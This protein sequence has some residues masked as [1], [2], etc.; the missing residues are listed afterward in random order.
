VSDAERE[1]EF[2]T[3]ARRTLDDAA[4]ATDPATRA[5]LRDA[6]AN[7]LRDAQRR[8]ARWMPAAGFAMASAAVLLAFALW[9]RDAPPL[10]QPDEDL[11]PLTAADDL[12]LYLDLEL[13]TWLDE[14]ADAG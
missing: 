3:Q 8:P 10:A 4:A 9:R 6:R 2:L 11:T 12:D 7:A 14:E 5:R 1:R 13:Y